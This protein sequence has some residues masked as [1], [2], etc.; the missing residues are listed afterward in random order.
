M[1]NMSTQAILELI[2]NVPDQAQNKVGQSDFFQAEMGN[3][4]EEDQSEFVEVAL[5]EIDA[6]DIGQKGTNVHSGILLFIVE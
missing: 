6:F 4:D 2:R 1:A 5:D 3:E